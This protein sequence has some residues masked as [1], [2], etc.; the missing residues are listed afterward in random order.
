M[1]FF[2]SSLFF[3]QVEVEQLVEELRHDAAARLWA[4]LSQLQ[5][6]RHLDALYNY[7]LTAKVIHTHTERARTSPHS[8]QLTRYLDALYNYA[9]TAKVHCNNEKVHDAC[10]R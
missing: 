2:S 10:Q 1:L 3:S 7:A 6:P 5:L 4:R 9:L 8:A